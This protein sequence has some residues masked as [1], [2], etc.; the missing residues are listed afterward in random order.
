MDKKNYLSQFP[1]PDRCLDG[2]LQGAH[3]VCRS[4]GT[5]Q[6][7]FYWPQMP[8][9]EQ[10]AVTWLYSELEETY[11][12]DTTPT[13]VIVALALGSWISGELATWALRTLA[14]QKGNITLLTP[15]LDRDGVVEVLDSFA[16]HFSQTLIY[17]YPPFAKNVIESARAKGV[18][19]ENHNIKLRLAGEGYSEQFR[20]YLNSLLGYDKGAVYTISSGYAST[21]FGRVG[22]ETPL[23][24]AMKR[25]LYDTGACEKILGTA[26]L[27]SV[28]QFD[29][30]GF[31]LEEAEGELVI[32][33]YQ[34][35]PLV[36]YRTGDQGE[37]VAYTQLLSRFR[38]EGLDPLDLLRK[39]GV[40]PS[41]V[42]PLPF[43]LVHGR[44]DGGVTFYGVNLPVGLVR[45]VLESA[46]F[47]RQN[48]T[49]NFQMRKSQDERLNP[50]LELVL[51]ERAAGFDHSGLPALF[52]RELADRSNEYA[53][54]LKTEGEKV[55]PVITV[56]PRDY[57]VANT[58]IR[59]VDKEH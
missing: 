32:T 38:D 21:D 54:V 9:Q 35:V 49:G 51:E 40:D 23:C 25:L 14:M 41:A 48:F 56:V 3:I 43:V 10:D 53:K 39:Q 18:A 36:R 11:S 46:A 15:G 42:K 58:K 26:T 5:T 52:A 17:S 2:T 13:L 19:V 47:F 20:D 33:K 31:Y 27:P 28:C 37:I 44:H 7:P 22:K 57:F 8:W 1:L 29:P 34:A 50:I 30:A 12:I 24:V 16:P 4:S 6:S 55:L 45:D 59:Y